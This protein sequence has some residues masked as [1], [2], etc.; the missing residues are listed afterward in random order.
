[1]NLL[2]ST[3]LFSITLVLAAC[4][5]SSN[6]DFS[7][8]IVEGAPSAPPH[9][10]VFDPAGGQ[11]PTTN[12]IFFRGSTDGTLNI[13]NADANPVIA[14]VNELDG[15]STSNPFT[16]AFG[17]PIDQASLAVGSTIRIFEVV[18]NAQGA[19]L[20]VT[21]EL[22]ATEIVAV[23]TGENGSTLALVPRAPLAE[24]TSFLVVLT[25]GIKGTDGKPAIS[26]SAYT[27]A[28]SG[29]PLVGSDFEALEPLRQLINNMEAIAVSQEI[30]KQSI[31]L[32]WSFTTQSITPVLK[33]V[34]E[35][36]TA[37]NIVMAP[38]GKTTNDIRAAFPGIADVNIGTLDIP[39]YLEAPSAENP[40]ATLT[41]Y[42][43]GVGGS[44]LTRF[45]TTP[46]VNTTLTIPVMM[47]TPNANSGQV[48]PEA[49]W[50]VVIYQHGI[51]RLRT[52]MLIY[53]DSMA[54]AGFA[55]IAIDLPLHGVPPTLED[56]SPNPFHADNT[57]FPADN[58][59]T[60][61]LDFVDNTTKA[62]GSDGLVDES[63]DSFINLRSLLT[64]R[65]NTR[66]GVSNLLVL[67]RSLEN[68]PNIDASRV[69]FIAHSLGGI[70]AVPYL[71][72]ETK[73]LPTSLVTT[74]GSISKIVN[75]SITFG[76]PIKAGLAASGISS[77]ADLTRFFGGVQF[78]VESADPINFAKAAAANHPIH[79]IEVVGSDTNVPD[80]V[81]PNSTTEI[82]AALL[83][84]NSVTE[85]A[86]NI[87]PGSAG[88]VRFTVGDHSSVL[89]PSRGAPEGGSFLNVFSEM[90]AQLRAFQVTQGT[91]IVITDDSL[92][93][94]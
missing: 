73:S 15:F 68:I 35:G 28:R 36:A 75:E 67:R 50:P 32:T 58:E 84:A 65:D 25:N 34:A 45:N 71:G 24:S 4:G 38:T 14:A 74:G 13:P 89:D 6:H 69:G 3:S 29:T 70:I 83:G 41:G 82:L 17:M 79:M 77:D 78:V 61:D 49:G 56:G 46:V 88:I 47:T 1:M 19:V 90:H 20:S 93:K 53:A 63:G 92:I 16:A 76:P 86:T 57:P 2:R 8:P 5:S 94:K 62:P 87:A 23:A 64:S 21:R 43:K 85:T 72:V 80:Q 7:Q 42:W 51:T 18:K 30:A 40:T 33:A 52:D 48:I 59:Q 10:P 39:Y 66:Q 27:I 37:G 54:A 91:T 26:A 9:G 55:V 22:S 11:I 12:D 31:V 44:S 60:F 81:V